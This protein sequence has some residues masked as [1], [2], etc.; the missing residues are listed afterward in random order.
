MALA[1]GAMDYDDD[2]LHRRV[3]IDRPRSAEP[4][5]IKAQAALQRLA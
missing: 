2:G 4:I 5:R 3:Q 1:D